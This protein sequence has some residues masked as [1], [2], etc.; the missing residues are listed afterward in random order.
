MFTGIPECV[1]ECG[2]IL[3]QIIQIYLKRI[4]SLTEYQALKSIHFN[5]LF[6]QMNPA[7]KTIIRDISG[8]Y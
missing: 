2:G 1:M 8:Q 5:W 3:N 7:F 4:L 6:K